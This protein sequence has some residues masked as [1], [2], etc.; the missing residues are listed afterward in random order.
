MGFRRDCRVGDVLV[1][2]WTVLLILVALVFVIL[3]NKKCFTKNKI[4]IVL[5][6]STLTHF[7]LTR[8]FIFLRSN[9][10]YVIKFIALCNN[11]ILIVLDKSTLTHFILT[12]IF[13]FFA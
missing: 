10:C 5:D 3:S 13:N 1:L 4:L 11:K 6:R 9:L 7:I 8:I 2:E 12:R